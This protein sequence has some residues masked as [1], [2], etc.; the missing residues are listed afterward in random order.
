MQECPFGKNPEW[1][2]P[3]A[4]QKERASQCLYGTEKAEHCQEP[5]KN[6]EF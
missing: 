2:G 4:G 5:E 6:T 1:D 3:I